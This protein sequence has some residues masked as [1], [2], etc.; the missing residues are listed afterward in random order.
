MLSLVE[1]VIENLNRFLGRLLDELNSQA[2]EIILQFPG[3]LHL[4]RLALSEND[5]FRF[6]PQN[7]LQIFDLDHMSL[8][9]PPG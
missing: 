2:L 1:P 9:S 4:S 7:G 3:G 5:C 6:V 8:F